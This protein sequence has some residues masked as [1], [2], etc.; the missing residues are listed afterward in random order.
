M[1]YGVAEELLRPLCEVKI[2]IQNYIEHLRESTE[3]LSAK[4][5]PFKRIH[6]L[7]DYQPTIDD[8]LTSL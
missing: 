4:S 3:V 6:L 5:N 8:A 1:F 2:P 7:L